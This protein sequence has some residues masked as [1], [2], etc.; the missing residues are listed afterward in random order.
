MKGISRGS[1]LNGR[2]LLDFVDRNNLSMINADKT[3]CTGTFT[4]IT[5]RSSTILD[6][7]LATE[8]HGQIVN[9]VCI[10]E[11]AKYLSGSDHVLVV[12]EVDLQRPSEEVQ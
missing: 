9:R 1:I 6:Y 7:V 4:R 10:D 5:R 3:R 11:E 2:L 12:A 8:S